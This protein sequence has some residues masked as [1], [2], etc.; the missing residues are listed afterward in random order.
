MEEGFVVYASFNEK[1]TSALKKVAA[2]Q[3]TLPRTAKFIYE[4]SKTRA[5]LNEFENALTTY[6]N[7][8]KNSERVPI[9]TDFYLPI[10]TI[11]NFLNDLASLEEK[12]GLE[13]ALYG[14]TSTSIYH[15]RPKFQLDDENFAKK[16]AVLLRAG[17]YVI[18]RQGGDFTGGTP[19]GRVKAVATSEDLPEEQR[20][21]YQ[22][23]KRIFDPHNILNPDV[24]LGADSKFTLTHL[25]TTSLPKVVV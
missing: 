16:V 7:A 22:E 9:L 11:E 3:K 12:T 18:N 4:S 19:E 14:S 1:R 2:I 8:P 5:T 10:H 13:L 6:L 17:A 21:V 24:K 15:L 23:I 25:R 20:K